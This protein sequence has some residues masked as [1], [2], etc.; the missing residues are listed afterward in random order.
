MTIT[1]PA[2][3]PP[4][5]P[6]LQPVAKEWTAQKWNRQRNKAHRAFVAHVRAIANASAN[7]TRS[8]RAVRAFLR[9]PEALLSAALRALGGEPGPEEAFALRDRLNLWSGTNEPVRWYLMSKQSGGYR[10]I[11]ILPPDLK[12]AHYMIGAA[13]A[14]QLPAVPTLYGIRHRGVADALR[15]LKTLQNA[16]FFHLAKTDIRDCFQ[17]VDPDAL[18]QL[19]LPMEVIRR[20]LDHRNL[21]FAGA[22][23][24]N[25]SQAIAGYS[26]S[27]YPPY[28]KASG[29]SGLLQGSP[30]SSVILA[31]LLKDIP[32][33]DG[34]R[35]LLCFDNIVVAAR[36]PDGTRQA[37]DT[38][39]AY[40]GHS[41]AGPLA[42]C[43]ATFADNE[44][45]EFLGGLF[46]PARRDIGIA[47]DTMS[48]SERRLGA[49]EE[50]DRM[51]L[52]QIWTEYQRLAAENALYR[53]V[54]PLEG[55]YPTDIWH[56]LRDTF[57]G[58]PFL[59]AD[60]PE[61]LMLLETSAVTVDMRGC[62]LASHLHQNLFAPAWTPEGATVRNILRSRPRPPKKK[63]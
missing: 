52:V 17:S 56:V 23:N 11:C 33:G 57:A 37:M 55:H 48:R 22:G 44:P 47:S 59:E 19:P 21:T 12:A 54:N 24:Q 32:A 4:S 27:V 13:I 40:L 1:P 53:A 58:L 9:D 25:A 35:V 15:E 26:S 28:H 29:P 5:A 45:M 61:L 42:L 34:A 10:H 46:D 51:E 38:V 39:T 6:T 16:G 50:T 49:V 63:R 3:S 8:T 7:G 20:T 18:Y 62:G 2:F 60:C 41:P 14:A 30:A 43:D 31:W 36:T